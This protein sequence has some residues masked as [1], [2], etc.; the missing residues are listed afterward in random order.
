MNKSKLI[1]VI[2]STILTV[3]LFT[4]P[5][6]HQSLPNYTSHFSILQCID[7]DISEH[8][9]Q[10]PYFISTIFKAN[11]GTINKQVTTQPLT[12]QSYGM[13]KGNGTTSTI[14]LKVGNDWQSYTITSKYIGSEAKLITMNKELTT[15]NY[16][17]IK[18]LN[19]TDFNH[20]NNNV[21]NTVNVM[22][23]EYN[24]LNK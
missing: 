10:T 15:T 17:T 20:K 8:Q 4:A 1:K 2:A 19:V 12:Y 6:L 23:N 14:Y 22:I 7:S 9:L 16:K 13:V 18:I 21:I 5:I 24:K 3:T 11:N